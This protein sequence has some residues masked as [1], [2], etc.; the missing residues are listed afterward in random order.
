MSCHYPSCMM[1]GGCSD[2]QECIAIAEDERRAVNERAK[3]K[4]KEWTVERAVDAAWEKN[5]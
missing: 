1:G 5:R 3:S 2:E 4:A